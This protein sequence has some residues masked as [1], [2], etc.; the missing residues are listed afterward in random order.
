MAINATFQ[1]PPAELPS[2]RESLV[3]KLYGENPTI[4][5]LY[6]LTPW[7]WLLDWFTGFGEY[8][9]IIERINT[10][11]SLINYGYITYASRGILRGDA[12]LSWIDSDTRYYRPDVSHTYTTK[13]TVGASSQYEFS[14]QKRVNMSDLGVASTLVEPSLNSFQSSILGALLAQRIR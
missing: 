6:N 10:D 14:F 8:V 11:P 7:S 1:F 9:N 2:L 3:D 5:T 13:R 12:T 4:D